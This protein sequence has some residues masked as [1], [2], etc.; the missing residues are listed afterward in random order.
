MRSDNYSDLKKNPN[1][2]SPTRAGS[3][4]SGGGAGSNGVSLG[5]IL[6]QTAKSPNVPTNNS[7][8]Q[9]KELYPSSK[10]LNALNSRMAFDSNLGDQ[11]SSKSF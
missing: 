2:Q 8:F 1:L 10:T 9:E 4:G 3:G 7:T 6:G 5:A 11:N